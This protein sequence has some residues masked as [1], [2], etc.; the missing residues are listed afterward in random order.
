MIYSWGYFNGL[1]DRQPK[2][3]PGHSW[4]KR[5]RHFLLGWHRLFSTKNTCFQV[6]SITSD[7]FFKRFGF[8]GP[9]RCIVLFPAI[10]SPFPVHLHMP[11][12]LTFLHLKDSVI[13][14]LFLTNLRLSLFISD[15]RRA[16]RE[17]EEAVPAAALDTN[18]ASILEV[19]I[20]LVLKDKH[21]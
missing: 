12:A 20:Q 7:S 14:E 16:E 17:E 8:L 1:K 3:I 13:P 2:K 15:Q 6:L 5:F 18:M 10:T 19:G 4:N 11:A 21:V 9:P